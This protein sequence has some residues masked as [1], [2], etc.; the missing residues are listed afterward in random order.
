MT[1]EKF[2]TPK[3][4]LEQERELFMTL[5]VIIR[6]LDVVPY[7]STYQAMQHFTETRHSETND[8]LWVLEHPPVY[9]LGVAGKLEHLL[10]PGNIPVHR[11]DRGGQVTY[12]GPGQLVVYILMD[13]QRRH[14]GIRQLVHSLEQSVIDYLATQNISGER[15]EKAPGVYVAGRKIASLGL[16]IRRGCSYHG[17]SFN[18]AMDLQPFRG[19]NPCGYAGLEVTQLSELGV[20]EAFQLVSRQYLQQLMIALSY[21]DFKESKL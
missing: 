1:T 20:T 14:W 7:F 13:L 10:N 11:V 15:H 21:D 4:R 17:L 2:I 6:Q 3:R 8:E 19:I 18:V 12:H 5:S 16:K 9:T